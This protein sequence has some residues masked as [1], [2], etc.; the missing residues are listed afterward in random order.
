MTS[1]YL[2]RYWQW[3]LAIALVPLLEYPSLAQIT[4]DNTLGAE[5]SVV[6][7]VDP[8]NDRIDG[9]AT[10]GANLFHSFE[11]FNIDQGRGVDFANP[12][13]I[14]NILSRVTGGNPSNIF[15]RLGVLGN[16]N[17]FLI[18]PNGIIFG[19]NSSLDV[20]GSF[21]GTTADAIAFGEN[22]FF[23]AINPQV[24]G[25]LLTVNPSAF[26][27]NQI[28]AGNIASSSVA[29]S[30][31]GSSILGLWVPDGESLTLLGGNVSIDGGGV[32]AGLNAF[33]GRVEIG[34]VS[35]TG[36]IGLNPD[37]SLIFPEEIERADVLFT[38]GVLVDVSSDNKGNIAITGRNIDV[39]DSFLRAG[40]FY[41]LGYPDSQAGDITLNATETLQIRGEESRILNVVFEDAIGNS[42]NIR[43][44]ADSLF[45]TDGARLD[46]TTFGQG[47]GGNILI[48]ARDQV[49]LDNGAEIFNDVEDNGNGTGGN[50]R[51]TTGSLSLA[52]NAQLSTTV[53]GQGNAGD[54]IIEARDSVSLG[55][56][57]RILNGVQQS[58]IGNGGTISI[59]AGK[60]SL[61]DEAFIA[62]F[63]FG[64]GNAGDILL[65]AG[66]RI[67]LDN[68]AVISNSGEDRN[69]GTIDINT[70]TLSLTD[71]A[72]IAAFTSGEGNA[73]DILIE[74]RD[75]ISLD[76]GAAIR[77]FGEDGNGGNIDLN[78]GTLSVTNS[79]LLKVTTSGEGNAGDILI[80]ASDRI[81]VD[82]GAIRNDV[83]EDGIGGIIRI[84][85]GDLSVANDALLGTSTFG[86]GDAGDVFIEARNLISLDNRVLIASEVGE[87]ATGNGGNVYITTGSLTATNL[88]IVQSI[89][90]GP[91]NAGN[92]IINARDQILF[93]G[94]I[95]GGVRSGANS[96]VQRG[97]T[98]RGGKV[99]ITT[100]S[101][102]LT[103]G[104]ILST[105]T[106]GQGD[107]GNIFINA[108]DT[109]SFFDS[110]ALSVIEK[111]AIGNG[112]NIHVTTGSLFLTNGSQLDTSVFEGGQGNA[113]NIIVNAS[114]TVLLDGASVDGEQ[115]STLF[116]QVDE[117]GVGNGGDVIVT[118]GSLFGTNGGRLQSNTEGQG[119]AGNVIVN[120]RDVVQFDG[121]S[122][123]GRLVSGVLSNVV[124]DAVGT[125]GNVEITTA[126]LLVTNGAQLDTSTEGQGSAGDVLINARDQ[127]FIA[128]GAVVQAQT[129][130]AFRGGNVAI[131]TKNLNLNDRAIISANSQG[132]GNAGG[133][134]I[135]LAET[136]TLNNSDITTA[137]N[138]SA[139]GA[140]NIQASNIRLYGDSDITTNVSNGAGGGGNITVTADSVIAFD[141]SDILAF[142]QTG[143]GGDIT[144]NTPAFFG[145]NF[146]PAPPGTDPFTLDENDR[147][148]VNASGAV[149]GNIDL[150]DVSAIQNGITQV[151]DN[152]I[153][154]DELIASSCIARTEQPDSTF[155]ITGTGGFPERPGDAQTS[156]FPLGTIRNIPS[157]SGTP[158]SRTWQEGDPIIEPQGVYRLPNGELVLSRECPQ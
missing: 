22:G 3:G 152:L 21:L 101:L 16:A 27:F 142:A 75:H 119:N 98:G 126:S 31:P 42:G 121:I 8:L 94:G 39:E 103:N 157:E 36:Q 45:L 85:T 12:D 81:F 96:S 25:Q 82:N 76:N 136:L 67:S 88:G 79:A 49:S 43:I 71:E 68:G 26:F 138:Q 153:N 135:T 118:T 90:T 127:I 120:A 122:R 37:G 20:G 15:G 116:S 66:D 1:N 102:L 108:R 93:E 58:G 128:N 5:S 44:T 151:T 124:G 155:Y 64:Q 53:D 132:S 73:G 80:E 4:P 62:A 106:F 97:A 125:G 19:P 146:Q 11:E 57:V 156:I 86:Q 133:V 114:D 117:G 154:T 34:A 113:G 72:F 63:T 131:N 89:T 123:D 60:L 87:Q 70:G 141:D 50:I 100:G 105:T 140:M 7:P 111:G 139:G 51:I 24:P 84:N 69:G 110:A 9:G 47:N 41:G 112:G 54:L 109:V 148:D 92:V 55:N 6:T 74:A 46:T 52:N 107:A 99:E 129:S 158:P 33:G 144:L 77:N 137:S 91:G 40:I 48:E 28:P 13:G 10:R 18:N 29:P 134:D 130:S 14:E 147:V 104:A 149:E 59:N 35:S 145:E 143:R 2:S 115:V 56:N 95:P 23:S 150:P 61:T 83:T 32:G 17:L 78:T 38:N 65:E 30:P